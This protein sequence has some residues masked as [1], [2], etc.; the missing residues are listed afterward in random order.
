MASGRNEQYVRSLGA[1]EFIDYT[2]QPFEKV[3]R[4]MDVIFDTVGGDTSILYC[5]N[6]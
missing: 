3:A 1:D 5:A 2:K 6:G 4:D